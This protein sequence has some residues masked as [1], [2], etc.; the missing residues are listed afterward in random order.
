M[1]KT[2]KQSQIESL[3]DQ[4]LDVTAQLE[5]E[6]ETILNLE[7]KIAEYEQAMA[8]AAQKVVEFAS[9]TADIVGKKSDQIAELEQDI[10]TVEGQL[11]RAVSLSNKLATLLVNATVYGTQA[12]KQ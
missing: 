4:I 12:D 5:A 2:S 3:Q 6:R 8:S 10:D 9:T 7:T 1:A 11:D